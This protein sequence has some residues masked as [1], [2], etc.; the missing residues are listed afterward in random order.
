M[1]NLSLQ[2]II[3]CPEFKG[4]IKGIEEELMEQFRNCRVSDNDKMTDIRYK[5]FAL[6][7]I[8]DELESKA[9]KEIY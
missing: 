9:Q 5:L 1:R 7:M 4:A 8:I 6:D 2:D 3:N